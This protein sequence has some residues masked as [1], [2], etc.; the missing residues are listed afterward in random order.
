MDR[1]GHGQGVLG[2]GVGQ[3]VSCAQGGRKGEVGGEGGGEGGAASSEGV[4]LVPTEPPTRG[5]PSH[6]R[7]V[8]AFLS[9]ATEVP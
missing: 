2:V 6:G 1:A 4:E 7:R 5:L 9:A 3:G 8:Q